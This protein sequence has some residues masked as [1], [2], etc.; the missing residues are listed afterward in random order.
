MQLKG[1]PFA[2]VSFAMIVGV[3]STAL[4]SPLYAMY[5]E[6]WVLQPS[7]VTLIYV[8]YMVGVLFGLLFVGRLP[9]RTGFKPMMQLG[10]A[11]V[12]VGTLI[13]ACAWNMSSL[14]VGRFIVGI[15][16]SLLTTSSSLGLTVLAKPGQIQR[17]STQISFLMALGFG[18]GPL[19]GGILGQ[20]APYPLVSTYLPT[21][22]LSLIALFVL[23]QLPLPEHAFPNPRQKLTLGDMLP[24][25]VWPEANLSYAF[26]LTCALP[27]LA[28][29]VFGLYASMS[30]LF[31]D[32]L[33]PWHGPVVSGTAIAVILLASALVQ[34]TVG[35]VD[36]RHSGFIGFVLLAVSN[37]LLMLNL[38][39]S[40]AVLFA[41][42]VA[43]TAIGHGFSMLAGM[44]MMSRIA[45]PHNR[46][47]LMST[48]LVIGYLGSMLPLL[49][50]GWIADHFGM[51][52]A[53]CTFCMMV[54]VLGTAFGWAYRKYWRQTL[55]GML[56]AHAAGNGSQI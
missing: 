40:S 45:K 30:P 2:W 21:V 39:M 16:S 5:K 22:V 14:I 10:L 56:E 47:G 23:K 53:V 11:L 37:G 46:T 15:A 44:G 49:G 9:D 12:F 8:I 43:I 50:I 7:D 51:T 41:L 24:K 19:V 26:I 1:S 20:W 25:L 35:R 34:I 54:I 42:G 27:F 3:M 13:S 52:V 48:Y 4:I 28:F 55:K 32:Q 18:L 31:L 6:T 33:V 36:I 29:G 38:W 17:V